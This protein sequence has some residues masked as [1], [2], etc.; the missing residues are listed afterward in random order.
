MSFCKG[1]FYF[2]ILSPLY[3]REWEE[4]IKA[5]YKQEALI[6]VLPE[7]RWYNSQKK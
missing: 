2:E 3:T 4:L 6:T 1:D 7:M 5:E